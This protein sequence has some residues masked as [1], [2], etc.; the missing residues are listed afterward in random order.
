MKDETQAKIEKTLDKVETRLEKIGTHFRKNKVTYLACGGT[1]VVAVVGTIIVLANKDESNPLQ[2]IQQIGLRNTTNTAIITLEENS[3]PSKPVHLIG[4]DLYFNSLS[5]ASR[6]TG[7]HLS[8]L[9]KHVNGQIPDLNGDV[10]E[11]LQVA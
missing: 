10:F 2:T 5:D 9:S 3:T 7:H 11:V 6:K 8:Q 4:T 1:A